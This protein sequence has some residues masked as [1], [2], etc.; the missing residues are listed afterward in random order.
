M[1]NKMDNKT[2][3]S[4]FIMMLNFRD[5][6]ACQAGKKVSMGNGKFGSVKS[7]FPALVTIL[8]VIKE[9]EEAMEYLIK[10]SKM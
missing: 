2:M 5:K 9:D 3:V 8:N 1:I 6:I 4:Q 10:L 7:I